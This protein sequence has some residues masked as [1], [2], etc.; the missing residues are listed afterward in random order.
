MTKKV[1]HIPWKAYTKEI[2]PGMRAGLML[3]KSTPVVEVNPT[4]LLEIAGSVAEVVLV[5]VGAVGV[6]ALALAAPNS[7]KALHA[8]GAAGKA[9]AKPTKSP[10]QA[11]AK[12]FHYLKKNK[13]IRFR[14]TKKGFVVM[15]T[16]KGRD[17]LQ[18][19]R[20]MPHCIQH[21]AAWDGKWWLIAADIPTQTHR[22]A[23]DLFRLKL[24]E[25]NVHALQR[26]M[27]VYPFDPRSELA[28]L[29]HYF[30]IQQFV[31]VM[32]INRL[33]ESDEVVLRKLYKKIL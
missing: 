20:D 6:T 13:Y 2:A 32:E 12:T 24:K 1:A 22:R 16:Q 19:L 18:K 26:S 28:Y 21:P 23:A 8:L 31:T 27:W 10:E 14:S 30:G 25:L 3:A 11:L 17:R 5:V 4:A 33:D 9:F 7:L 29:I 15:L